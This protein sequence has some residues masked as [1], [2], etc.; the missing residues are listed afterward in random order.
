MGSLEPCPQAGTLAGTCLLSWTRNTHRPP[1]GKPGPWVL[2]TQSGSPLWKG[3]E[4]TSGEK[5]LG[6]WSFLLHRCS[7]PAVE[8]SL[9]FRALVS[10]SVKWVLREL[11]ISVSSQRHGG[12]FDL[13]MQIT[14]Q[15]SG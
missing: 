7:F 5:D 10:P 2:L 11:G 3:E 1:L 4:G 8:M 9:A 12:R 6:V 13:L 14:V 15:N